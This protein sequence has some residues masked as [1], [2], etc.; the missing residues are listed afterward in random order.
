MQYSTPGTFFHF[1]KN[2]TFCYLAFFSSRLQRQLVVGPEGAAL[3]GVAILML[4]N[5]LCTSK[6][7]L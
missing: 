3:N 4:E 5:P 7:G 6:V 1:L 2:N